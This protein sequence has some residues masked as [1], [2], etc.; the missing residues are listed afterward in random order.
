MRRYDRNLAARS[1]SGR[2]HDA[3]PPR[4]SS[5][6]PPLLVRFFLLRTDVGHHVSH[7]LTNSTNP[8]KLLVYSASKQDRSPLYVVLSCRFSRSCHI[9]FRFFKLIFLLPS[10]QQIGIRERLFSCCHLLHWPFQLFMYPCFQFS[11]SHVWVIIG[12]PP[13]GEV[14]TVK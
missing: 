13:R 12:R 7:S 6:R 1:G 4:I 8:V 5:G 10:Q 9:S 14:S 3:F 11:Y 2:K